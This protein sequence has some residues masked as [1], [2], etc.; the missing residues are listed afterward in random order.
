[1]EGGHHPA[2]AVC[3]TLFYDLGIYIVLVH[4]RRSGLSLLIRVGAR[5]RSI[6]EGKLELLDRGDL[7]RKRRPSNQLRASCAAQIPERVTRF[8]GGLGFARTLPE[9]N[10]AGCA[11]GAVKNKQ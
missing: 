6:E 8:K 9:G 10:G 7:I 5:G 2:A 4:D 11:R 3:R 1:V